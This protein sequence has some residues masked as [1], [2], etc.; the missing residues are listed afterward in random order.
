MDGF[1]VMAVLVLVVERF[2]PPAVE[3]EDARVLY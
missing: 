2:R 3:E 1:G